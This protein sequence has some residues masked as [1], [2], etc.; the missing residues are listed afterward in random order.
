MGQRLFFKLAFEDGVPGDI[1][2][3]RLV[4]RFGPEIC[5]HSTVTDWR[6]EF[7]GGRQNVEDDPDIGLQVRIPGLIEQ[8]PTASVRTVAQAT[9]YTVSTVFD[10]APAHL[11][12]AIAA[13][14]MSPHS[15]NDDH[16]AHRVEGARF[17]WLELWIAVQDP[18][19]WQ[20]A[21]AFPLLCPL[22]RGK[23]FRTGRSPEFLR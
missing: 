21:P 1:T 2:H 9:G 11:A 5:C 18:W 19:E 12:F 17:P 22:A 10:I 8:E 13:F 6:R 7:R 3:Q 16:K 23:Q 4:K 14:A 20:G 15:L